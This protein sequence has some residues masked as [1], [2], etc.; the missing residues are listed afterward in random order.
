MSS[1]L[2]YA[3]TFFRGG[4]YW[5]QPLDTFEAELQRFHRMLH[6]LSEH[7]ERGDDLLQ[8]T[9]EQLLQGPFSDAMT[10]AGQIAMLRRLYGSAVPPENF[11]V[12]DIDPKRLGEDQADARAPDAE[13]P[14]R[15]PAD[16]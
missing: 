6:D 11:V 8:V 7:L 14:E 9:P 4:T 1:V 10:H 12:A 2:G 3:R 5:P 16:S 13:W 15:L